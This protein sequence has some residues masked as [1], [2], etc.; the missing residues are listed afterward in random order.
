MDWSCTVLSLPQEINYFV[1]IWTL[2]CSN[3]RSI[4]TDVL[5]SVQSWSLQ[6]FL[7]EMSDGTNIKSYWSRINETLLKGSLYVMVVFMKPGRIDFL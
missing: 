4:T 3:S 1:F 7:I 2:L 5:K 6:S